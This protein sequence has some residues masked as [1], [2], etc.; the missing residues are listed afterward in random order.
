MSNQ[1]SL[2]N[3]FEV[4]AHRGNSRSQMNPKLK[5][6]IYGYQQGLC[7]IDLTETIASLEKVTTLLKKQGERRKQIL[8]VGTSRYLESKTAKYAGQFGSGSP[9]VNNRWL[10]GTIT[11]WSTVRKTLKNLE[12]LENIQDNT[13]FFNKLARNEQLN[14]A[15]EQARMEKF[16]GGLKTLKNNRPGAVLILDTA[17][18]PVAI[19]EA[20]AMNVPVIALTNTTVPY[21]PQ[22]LAH[23]VL[24]NNHSLNALDMVM[25]ELASAYNKGLESQVSKDTKDKA[26]TKETVKTKV[27]A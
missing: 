23:T 12:K 14:V 19:K 20:E 21:L 1:I 2:M 25:G 16:F 22:N 9:Y 3:L 18:N 8:L 11:N 4:G 26:Q 5:S 10:G 6:R 27:T 24:F 17:A 15:K 13:E 7:V